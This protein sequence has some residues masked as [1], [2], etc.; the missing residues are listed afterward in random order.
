MGNTLLVTMMHADPIAICD[1]MLQRRGEYFLRVR[2]HLNRGQADFVYRVEIEKVQPSLSISIPRVDRYS[3]LRQQICVPQGN[4]FAT[5]IS[6]NRRNFGGALEL[7]EADWPDGISV[8]V[9]PM[10]ANLN[11]MPVVFSA[12]EDA[13]LSGKLVDLKARHLDASKNIVGTFGLRADFSLGPPNRALYFYSDV[14]K[15]ASAV[16][17]KVPFRIE[18][19]Q[20]Q[21]PLVRN[22]SMNLKI[23]AHREAG[24]DQPINI[25]FPFRPPG[26]G[27]KPQIQIAKGKNEAY[28]P[29]NANGSA[30]IGKWP[31][32]AIGQSNVEGPVWVST[33]L[34]E[35]EIAE[36][37]VTME[38]PR[39]SCH[40]G[41]TTNVFCKLNH[42]APFEGEARAE[43]LGVPPHIE[44]PQLNFN[45]ETQELNFEVKTNGKS[46]I[47]KHKGLFCRI[48]ITQN[49]EPIVSTAARSE[50]RINK[51]KPKPTTHAGIEKSKAKPV[52]QK[53]KPKSRLQQL[54]EAAK[55]KAGQ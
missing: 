8:D 49:G 12:A 23:V 31:I 32:Y 53:P 47:G 10:A 36:P 11:L 18:I 54:R 39:T 29:L 4:R 40:Q 19:V 27:T 35:L 3:Q 22:G 9:K 46:R 5:M 26:L 6:A 15:L 14:Y 38:I 16:T 7:L 50:L 45:K 51:P 17:K 13:K 52:A 21:V 43:L 25:Q 24:F 41:E 2:D 44:I 34:A 20:P 30:Q 1:S 42:R 28:Y 48:T 55:A 37:Y 33:Q